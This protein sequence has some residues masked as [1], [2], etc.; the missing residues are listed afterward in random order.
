MKP[1]VIVM[2]FTDKIY[3]TS[4]NRPQFK[5]Y[6]TVFEMLQFDDPVVA[7]VL[8]DQKQIESILLLPDRTHSHIIEK[9]ATQQCNQAYL[10]NGD[11]L[12]GKFF[13]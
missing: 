11:Q 4:K 9:K 12:L 5:E 13:F 8:I 1:R 7:N 10:M 6:P 3:D 2:D